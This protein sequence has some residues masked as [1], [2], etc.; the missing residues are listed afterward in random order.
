MANLER[1]IQ[2]ANIE[3]LSS[4]SDFTKEEKDAMD[5]FFNEF[6]KKDIVFDELLKAVGK[7]KYE[8]IV[9][10]VGESNKDYFGFAKILKENPND[11]IEIFN[12]CFAYFDI[13][14][15]DKY[16][17]KHTKNALESVLNIYSRI[18]DFCLDH[19]YSDVTFGTVLTK[20]YDCSEKIANNIVEAFGKHRDHLMLVKILRQ[21]NRR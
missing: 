5:A 20:Y 15:F 21:T 7:E 19:N 6:L 8:N 14:C 2:L 4:K 16:Q 17:K 3:N 9:S 11:L 13:A 12:N 1:L 18:S 10:F